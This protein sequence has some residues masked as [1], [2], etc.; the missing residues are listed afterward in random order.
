MFVDTQIYPDNLWKH[1]LFHTW[2]QL[3]WHPW[4]PGFP[5]LSKGMDYTVNFPF[6]W[7]PPWHCLDITFLLL[8][9]VAN[10]LVVNIY[11]STFIWDMNLWR[12]NPLSKQRMIL[13]R[14]WRWALKRKK[15]NWLWKSQSIL[16]DNTSEEKD[17]RVVS[18]KE[19]VPSNSCSTYLPLDFEPT[20]S[21]LVSTFCQKSSC[22]GIQFDTPYV[23]ASLISPMGVSHPTQN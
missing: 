2:G 14:D 9:F 23:Q 18:L 12:M 16:A 21:S 7:L 6:T 22:K 4:S 17:T 15:K 3:F 5:K 19:K 20:D 8:Q 11:T 13:A 1:T 10:H